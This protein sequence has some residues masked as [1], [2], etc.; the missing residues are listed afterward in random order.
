MAGMPCGEYLSPLSK[1]GMC[2]IARRASAH[3]F[4]PV[5]LF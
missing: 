3:S 2:A 5:H 4:V 1:Q